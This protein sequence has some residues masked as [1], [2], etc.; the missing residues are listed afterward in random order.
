MF[1]EYLLGK[2]SRLRRSR[3]P[4]AAKDLPSV[5]ENKNIMSLCCGMI[6]FGCILLRTL[7]S[8][9]LIIP[10]FENPSIKVLYYDPVNPHTIPS[11]YYLISTFFIHI[12]QPSKHNYPIDNG[13]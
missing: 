8:K 4:Q 12:I 7:S 1:Y 6:F 2:R 11:I 5:R 3:R 13:K 10:L 9:P